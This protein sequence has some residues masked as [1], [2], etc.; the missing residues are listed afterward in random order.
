M[1]PLNIPCPSA[2]PQHS[3][4]NSR[5]QHEHC[6][7]S[8]LY[9]SGPNP[10]YNSPT[11]TPMCLPTHQ[12]WTAC[13]WG[14]STHRSQLQRSAAPSDDSWKNRWRAGG[15]LHPGAATPGAAAL[16]LGQPP[17][18]LQVV[19][20]LVLDW[21]R[22]RPPLPPAPPLKSLPLHASS[23]AC[24]GAALSREPASTAGLGSLSS[25]A[26][27]RR[28]SSSGGGATSAADVAAC[29]PPRSKGPLLQLPTCSCCWQYWCMWSLV[30]RPCGLWCQAGAAPCWA[31]LSWR[32]AHQVPV[33]ASKNRMGYRMA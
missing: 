18:P 4:F 33:L 3:E 9:P 5:Q 10:Q 19:V 25:Q 21:Q 12:Q 1:P 2:S 13:T 24:A 28:G 6:R 32:A 15:A 26:P 17:P 29:S 14:S 11:H 23:A 8:Q 31:R 7:P 20:V 30:G 27:R 16:Q 22:A